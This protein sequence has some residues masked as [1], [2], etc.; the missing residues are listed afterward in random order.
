MK[1]IFIISGI[2]LLAVLG[3]LAFGIDSQNLGVQIPTTTGTTTSLVASSSVVQL[4]GYKSDRQYAAISNTGSN[5]AFL[6]LNA[7]S[8]GFTAGEGIALFASS[9]YE[10]NDLNLWTGPV[11]IIT[12]SGTTSIAVQ[13]N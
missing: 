8:S 11:W 13:E 12:T 2:V 7:T 4:L 10:I 6:S 5:T 9:K 3:Y 1:Y